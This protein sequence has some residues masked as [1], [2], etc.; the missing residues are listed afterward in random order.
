M[1]PSGHTG[2]TFLIF[3]YFFKRFGWD[4][5]T[6]FSFVSFVVVVLALLLSRGHYSID[7][8][9][10]VLSGYFA[11]NLAR[12]PNVQKIMGYEIGW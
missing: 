8:V 9:G 12:H 2:F 6:T 11:Y 5:V 7:I 4:V 10:G 3:F 1:F